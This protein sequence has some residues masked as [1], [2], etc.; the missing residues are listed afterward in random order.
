MQFRY[1]SLGSLTRPEQGKQTSTM[2]LFNKCTY[3]EEGWVLIE[4]TV[5]LKDGLINLY[6]VA[7]HQKTVNSAKW[8]E[9][10]WRSS[11]K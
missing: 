9:K 3:T 5:I 11:I 10:K 2:D 7:S 4:Q 6:K 8:E 1:Q